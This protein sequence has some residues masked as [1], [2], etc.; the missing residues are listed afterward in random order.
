M[1]PPAAGME[2]AWLVGLPPVWWHEPLT[3]TQRHRCEDTAEDKSFMTWS[4]QAVVLTTRI[5]DHGLAWAIEAALRGEVLARGRDQ[6]AAAC[7]RAARLVPPGGCG[8]ARNDCGLWVCAA[9]VAGVG[10]RGAAVG[11]A[12]GGHDAE[13]VLVLDKQPD[14][15]R[16][17]TR[18]SCSRSHS[19][20]TTSGG[21][22]GGGGSSISSSSSSAGI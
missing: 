16:E 3:A 13:R 17:G 22:G 9:A 8:S 14:Q 20:T 11:L 5:H 12:A 15:S 7:E 21:G 10:G 1:A 6:R 4:S 18:S 19:R 2:K